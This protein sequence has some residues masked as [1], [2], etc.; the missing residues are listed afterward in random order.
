MNWEKSLEEH[1]HKELH[2]E[3][4]IILISTILWAVLLW[5][6]SCNI[7]NSNKTS[8]VGNFQ[9]WSIYILI[10]Y[11]DLFIIWPL[12]A[13]FGIIMLSYTHKEFI[14]FLYNFCYDV[15]T[16][17]E[18]QEWNSRNALSV[19]SAFLFNATK[20]KSTDRQNT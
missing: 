12:N 1:S 14:Y 9:T 16:I 17:K 10:L 19:R 11:F 3:K 15:L 4:N 5:N 18:L 2:K 20:S 13:F 7:F 8:S 6:V